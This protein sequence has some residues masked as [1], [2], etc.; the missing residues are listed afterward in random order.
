[1]MMTSDLQT[2]DEKMHL[3]TR[4]L[5]EVM[6]GESA[7]EHIRDIVEHRDLKLYWETDIIGDLHVSNFVTL[8]KLTDFLHAGCEVIILF[9]DLH[10]FLRYVNTPLELLEPH[11]LYYQ[12]VLTSMLNIIGAPLEK[13]KFVRASEHQLSREYT[14]DFY[15]LSTMTSIRSSKKPGESLLSGMLYPLLQALDEQYLDVDAQFGGFDQLKQF[16]LAEKCLPK[17]GYS[18]RVHLMGTYAK[19]SM[20]WDHI[21]KIRVQDAPTES[22]KKIIK[23]SF[24]EEGKVEKNS[25]LLFTKMILFPLCKQNGF[26]VLRQQQHGG[27]SMYQTYEQLEKAFIAKEIHP[28]DLK[29]SVSSLLLDIL[30][31]IQS[32]E[33]KDLFS[34][35][36]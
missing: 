25:V 10:K 7:I 20:L 35:V 16:A 18:K 33:F 29:N 8:L 11:I 27:N 23:N 34:T 1:M 17:L 4:N 21:F 26:Q 9:A 31:T 24:C 36:E 13:L 5:S 3:I 22:I 12:H 19:N 28:G 30:K 14:L 15:K 2:L 32:P 6:G